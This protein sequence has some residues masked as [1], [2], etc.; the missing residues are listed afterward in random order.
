MPRIAILGAQG[1]FL[2]EAMKRNVI[3]AGSNVVIDSRDEKGTFLSIG[4]GAGLTNI[5]EFGPDISIGNGSGVAGTSTFTSSALPACTIMQGQFISQLNPPGTSSTQTFNVYLDAV[6]IFGPVIITCTDTAIPAEQDFD[7]NISVT[8][9]Q[10][11]SLQLTNDPAEDGAW[12]CLING[13]V[14]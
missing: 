13:I 8:A 2:V 4:S 7:A 6:L 11:L 5:W 14:S 1:K 12:D 10:I 9:G 3:I